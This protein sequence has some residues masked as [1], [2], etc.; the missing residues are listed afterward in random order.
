M[1]EHRLVMEQFLGRYLKPEEVVHHRNGI[2]TDNRIE[3]LKIFK[4][5]KEHIEYHDS[6]Q[7]EKIKRFNVYCHLIR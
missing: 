6:L 3:N 5:N 7:E 2:K 1:L 4:N